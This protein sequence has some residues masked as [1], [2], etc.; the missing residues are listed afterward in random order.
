[1]L[2]IVFTFAMFVSATLLFLVEPMLAKM[3]LPMLGG[4]PAVWNTCLVFFQAVL[5]AGYLYAYAS[6]KWLGRRTQ[7]GV[8]IGVALLP[9]A[10]LPL[11]LPAGWE[12]PSQSTPVLWVLAM[13]SVA[14]GLP[15]FVLSSSTPML[16]RWFSE[17]GHAQASD[18]YFLYAASNAGSLVGLL[19]YPLLL[20][21]MLRLSAQSGLWSYGYGLFFAM[22]VACGVLVWR[23]NPG[24]SAVTL[25]AGEEIGNASARVE[26]PRT[27]WKQRLRWIALAFVPSSLM[28]GVT[29][30]LTT[31]VPAIPLF[32]VLPLA[33]YLL[34]FVLV[35][36][37]RPPI[38]HEWL[39]RRLPFLI[40]VALIPTVCKTK[41]PLLILIAIYLSTLFAIALVC[42]GELARNRPKVSRLTEFYLWMSFGGVLGGIF[43]ALVAPVIF[44][45]VAEFPLVLVCA[46]LLRPPID[47]VPLPADKAA[48]AKRN[49]W[50]LPIALGLCMVAVIEGLAHEGLRPG[51]P[52]VILIFGYSML[53]C[54][55]FGKRPFRFA[56]GLVVLLAASSLYTGPFGEILHTE[57]SFFG[58]SRVTNDPTGKFRNL[59]HGGTSHGLQNLDPAKSRDPLAYYTTS[60]PA[61]TILRALEAKTI[62]D[63]DGGARK[64]AWAVVGLGAGAMACYAQPGE[65]LTYYEID[66][67]V[68]RIA[69]NPR[70]FT[71]LSQCA[72]TAPIVL[73]DARL[74]LRDA[75]DG[76]YD[77]IVLDAFSGDTIPMHLMTREALT[78]YVRK[79]A[80]GGMLAFHI[81]NL[82]LQLGPT[83]G[84]L[85]KDA[86]MVCLTAD[87]TGVAQAQ[88]DEG[89]FPSQWVVMARSRADLG[90]VGTDAR[91][92]DADVPTGTQLWTDDYS[93]LLHVI[94]W[95]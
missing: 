42:H 17:S 16:Q 5:L 19:G 70:Y 78:L 23:A 55:S 7:I 14:V 66:P 36:A 6:T 29:T 52:L 25:V 75:P 27:L 10:V 30:Q 13:L 61:G 73:G 28:L 87:D 2:L 48:R 9:L 82:Y 79:L 67:T 41:L 56:A 81:S 85:A 45:S 50:L 69:S 63:K 35:F 72:P 47:I 20:E 15:F 60:G 65:S 22:T 77:L 53:W 34:S 33:V 94:K 32:W 80:P 8:Q 43:N 84:E 37:K 39:I 40:L 91:W 64:P 93:N 1:M 58:V 24:L 38:S 74:K 31:D 12:P 83:L 21:P 76:S 62:V 68:K 90:A 57:R 3:A 59:F 92:K 88:I 4:T 11:H 49:D 86:G 54:M 89:K 71:F 44:S 95:N 26:V 18:P 46:A 51:R